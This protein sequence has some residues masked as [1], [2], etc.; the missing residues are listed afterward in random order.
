MA[1]Q[2][3]STA[4][5]DE[6]ILGITLCTK[7]AK[8]LFNEGCLLFDNGCVERAFTLFQLSIE[9]IGKSKILYSLLL[10]TKMKFEIN[11]KEIDAEFFHH[12]KKA[13]ASMNYELVAI[14]V[15][16]W[17]KKDKEDISGYKKYID[18]L[19]SENGVNATKANEMKNNS[20]Y[21]GYAN[22]KFSAPRDVI[23]KENVE[24]LRY[25][26]A[27]RL[28]ASDTILNAFVGD[29]DKLAEGI[30]KIQNDPNYNFDK[31]IRSLFE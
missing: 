21:V 13:K 22:G 7:N 6:I 12:A 11:W 31:D 28:A 4:S 3:L 5:V 15:L 23:T 29:I 30:L 18:T 19:I 1:N 10:N 25:T 2:S 24:S 20:L 27:I 9:E 8:E 17:G 16:A 14:I 26:L